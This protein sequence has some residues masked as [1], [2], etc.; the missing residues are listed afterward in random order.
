MVPTT[1]IATGLYPAHRF[2]QISCVE[3]SLIRLRKRPCHH[4][5]DSD[6]PSLQPITVRSI[7]WSHPTPVT[8][9]L[10]TS[11]CT[12]SEI[13]S[14]KR[15]LSYANGW[16]AEI[17]YKIAAADVPA[18]VAAHYLDT[19]PGASGLTVAQIDDEPWME[20]DVVQSS[21]LS[22]TRKL[23]YHF[24]LAYLDVPWPDAIPRP[25]YAAGT[26][27]RL[28]VRFSGQ[29]VTLPNHALKSTTTYTPSS[30]PDGSP[31]TGGPIEKPVDAAATA[32]LLVPIL[33]YLVEWDRVTD[34]SALD[35]SA[36]V[37]Q[38]NSSSFMGCDAGD[39]A[40]RGRV[41]RSGLRAQS[42]RAV[43]LQGAGLFQEAGDHL[44]RR[45][46]RLEPSDLRPA[47]QPRPR[48][49]AD[50]RRHAALCGHGFHELFPR[51]DRPRRMGQRKSRKEIRMSRHSVLIRSHFSRRPPP[52]PPSHVH[53]VPTFPSRHAGLPDR[54][55]LA[56]RRRAGTGR[57]GE[58]RAGGRF[59]EAR[60]RPSP[61]RAGCR[62]TRPIFPG[63]P[64]SR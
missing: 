32:T 34:L 50:Q 14:M 52:K 51:I 61:G 48:R 17:V 43:L 20:G 4:A 64:C 28:S 22:Q 45:L 40:V 19:Y 59:P 38:V 46:R 33:D 10:K 12:M 58:G 42:G 54:T 60:S 37:G 29:Y 15:T 11:N 57:G 8:R 39:A 18:H 35:F 3:P 62:S 1:R 21:G 36:Y 2:S 63:W 41:H 6:E 55:Q 49:G 13:V 31:Y 44:Q 25:G 7:S 16:A 47:V 30:N 9:T 24:A 27:L 56:P 53:T 5:Y 26:T 23:S